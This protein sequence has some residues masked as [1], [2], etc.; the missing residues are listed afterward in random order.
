MKALAGA[1][2]A[3]GALRQRLPGL[4]LLSQKPDD[5]W[6]PRAKG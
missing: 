2:D 3:D 5:D 6:V 4:G 1:S